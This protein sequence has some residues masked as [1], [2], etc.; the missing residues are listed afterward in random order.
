[1]L[2]GVAS[3]FSP[4]KLNSE[5]GC[6][7]KPVGESQVK[8]DWEK[9]HDFFVVVQEKEKKREKVAVGLILFPF[10]SYISW[11]SFTAESDFLGSCAIVINDTVTEGDS[12]WTS[13]K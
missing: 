10:L 7:F 3:A 8:W 12:F 13:K 2:T 5:C 1:M 6:F 11:A 9:Y 4:V